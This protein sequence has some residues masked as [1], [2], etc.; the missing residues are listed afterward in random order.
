MPYKEIKVTCTE[1]EGRGRVSQVGTET[2]PSCGGNG[3]NFWGRNCKECDG[4]GWVYASVEC[5]KC[6]GYGEVKEREYYC[7]DC[8][9]F[10]C[11][12]R[13]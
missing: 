7:G 8:G 12:C 1:C 9:N 5:P 3:K 4:Y 10:S 13:D 6:D 11:T 2:C